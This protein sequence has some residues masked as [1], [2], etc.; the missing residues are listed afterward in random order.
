MLLPLPQRHITAVQS[1]PGF[2]C[3]V[4][5]VMQCAQR[6]GSLY[7]PQ[8]QGTQGCTAVMCPALYLCHCSLSSIST[9]IALVSSA[10]LQ[11]EW[12]KDKELP[13][14]TH[15]KMLEVIQEA[16]QNIRCNFLTRGS[17]KQTPQHQQR[18]PSTTQGSCQHCYR[19][20]CAHPFRCACSGTQTP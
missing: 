16:L 12:T 7:H 5:L 18:V 19:W 14:E 2:G 10:L 8:A 4:S 1:L 17:A 3:C 9:T 6:A 15:H 20:V 11:P 13:V